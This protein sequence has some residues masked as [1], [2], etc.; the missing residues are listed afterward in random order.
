MQNICDTVCLPFTCNG[1][2]ETCELFL[3]LQYFEETVTSTTSHQTTSRAAAV[4][5][6][7]EDNSE[8]QN[9]QLIMLGT[10]MP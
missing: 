8:K 3:Y 7:V 6:Q 9:Q 2:F 1:D 4:T 5:Q 10:C